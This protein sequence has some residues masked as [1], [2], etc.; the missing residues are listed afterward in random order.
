VKPAVELKTLGLCDYRQ[1][2]RAMQQYTLARNADSAD[3]LWSVE[4]A[5]VYTLGLNGKAEHRL[6]DNGIDCVET[7]RGGQITYHGPGQLIVYALIDLHRHKLN[8]RTLVDLLEHG[9]LHTLL[10]Y[11]IHA[12]SRADAP[13][14]YVG[15]DKIGALGLRIRN[16]CSYHGLSLNNC[17]DLQPFLD[18]NPCG[19][20]GQ[21]VTSLRALGVDIGNQELAVP[22]LHYLCQHLES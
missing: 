21:G 2:W 13:G 6:R 10:Q 5:P 7:D 17:C 16:G 11:G 9:M 12:H 18:I 19:Y 1:T 15:D 14:V 20:A 8:A 22:L 4:H 3:Q